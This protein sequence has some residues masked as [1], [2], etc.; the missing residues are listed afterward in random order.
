MTIKTALKAN[1]VF[2]SVDEDYID[3][4]LD[5]RSIDGSQ[6]Y[7]S[8]SLKDFELA[9]ADLY[10]SLALVPEFKEGQLSVKMSSSLLLSRARKLYDKH[11]EAH[12]LG[13]GKIESV[14]V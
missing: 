7:T 2:A 3:N 5:L 9:T 13:F 8:S 1:P 10:A 12:D 14:D 11:G 4:V 6:A